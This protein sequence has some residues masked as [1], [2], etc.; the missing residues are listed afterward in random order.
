[1]VLILVVVLVAFA[2]PLYLNT[3]NDER[4]V[5]VKAN[6]HIAQMAADAYATDSGGVYPPAN[7]DPGYLSY[8]PAGS[9]DLSGSKRGNLPINPFTH[10]SEPPQPG[11]VLDIAQE[12]M[13]SPPK[14]GLPGQ[15]FYTAISNAGGA[16]SSYAIEGAGKDGIAL[17][18]EK[19]G[20]TLILS[21]AKPAALPTD[22]K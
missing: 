22:E 3:R 18:G 21:P 10:L 20:T 6:M 2:L 17:S 13:Q 14:L 4:A 7:D 1:M 8:F 16:I 19:P 11:A 15:I 12:R 9:R 5:L